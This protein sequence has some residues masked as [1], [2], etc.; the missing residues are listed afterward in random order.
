MV[1]VV[2]SLIWLVFVG[3]CGCNAA[4]AHAALI[5]S[6][7]FD[8]AVVEL[9]PASVRLRFNEP[10][11]PLIVSVTDARGHVH[12]DLASSARNEV[13]EI[14]M[15]SDLPQGSQ[16]LSYRVTSGDGHPIG[17]SIVFSIGASTESSS[18]PDM[19]GSVGVRRTLWLARMALYLGLFV[20]VGGAFFQAW[21]AP[22]SSSGTERVLTGFL[23][24]GF[25]A[26]VMSLGLHGLDALG[27]PLAALVSYAGWAAGWRT[28]FGS[29]VAAGMTALFIAWIGLRGSTRRRRACSLLAMIGIGLSLASSGHASTAAP[30]WLTRPAVFLHSAGVAYWVGALIPLLSAVRQAPAQALA[31]LRRFSTGA[32]V[33][34]AILTLAGLLLAAIQVADPVNLTS[35]AYGRVLI[36][37]TLIVAALI[38][39]AALN[40][41]WLTPALA[42]RSGSGG[43]WLVRSVAT[44]ITL[45]FAILALVGLW[46]LTP[47]PR[48]LAA[49]AETAASANVHLHSPRTMAQVT[50]SPGRAGA[51]QARI[52]IASGNAEKIVPKEVSLILAKP[53]EGIE[54]IKRRARKAERDGWEV[55]TLV[56]VSAGVWQ[57]KVEILIDD[58]EKASLAGEIVVRP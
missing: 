29:T 21:L 49:A 19:E 11:S 43:T 54:P 26:A 44:E 50:L 27:A 57:T 36:I 8:G 30:Q 40:R 56:L 24:M 22:S 25:L 58:F 45:V 37:K 41:L 55:D 1:R 23:V 46:R 3:L 20:G 17:G 33:A 38:G 10:V 48:A 18:T 9:A 47:P 16:V 5:Q 2:V 42:A 39:L 28:S 12:R 35:T 51:V 14:M 4:L 53:D 7:P 15:P 31:T 13:L 34:V 32:L 6:H 52:V